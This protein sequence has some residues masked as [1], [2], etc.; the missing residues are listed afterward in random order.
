[1]SGRL[2]SP[3]VDGVLREVLRWVGVPIAWAAL[4]LLQ[5]SNRKIGL[6]L[7]YHG[8]REHP[9]PAGTVLLPDHDT[10]VF[11]RQARY[12]GRHY[13]IVAASQLREA[14]GCRKRG[15]RFPL[16]ITFDDDLPSHR[17]TSLPVLQRLGLTATFFV[18]GASLSEPFS[19]WWERLDRATAHDVDVAAEIPFLRAKLPRTRLPATKTTIQQIGEFIKALPL[20]ERDEI[21]DQLGSAVGPDPAGAGMRASDIRVLRDAGFEIGFHTLRH[22]FLPALDDESL[23]DAMTEGR[24]RL[25]AI[26]GG[27]LTTISYPH[28]GVDDRV[29][30]AAREAGFRYGFTMEADAITPADDSLRIGRIVP[31][32]DSTGHL[33]ARL[34][35]AL[36]TS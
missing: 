12:L 33:A 10:G 8:V 27:P 35:H 13:R 16:A 11:A 3:N 7:A 26:T 6:A 36:A 5:R 25:S 24:E 29:A 2:T 19:F 28:G 32:F 31:S 23:R 30:A 22:A 1:M 14:I 18:C 20:A 15:D 4:W 21:A 17:L 34:V 9:L